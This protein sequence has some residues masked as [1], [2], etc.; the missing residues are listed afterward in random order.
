MQRIYNCDP[1][2]GPCSLGHHDDCGEE[3]EHKLTATV[4]ERPDEI[5]A[6]RLLSLRGALELETKGLRFRIS[7]AEA[8]RKELGSTTRS[9]KKLL[10]EFNAYLAE[11]GIRNVSVGGAR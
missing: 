9:K 3:C 1:T 4:F 11:R 7:R 8:V 6:F 2:C 5:A 10:A